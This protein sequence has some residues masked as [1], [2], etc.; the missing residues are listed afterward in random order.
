MNKE[1]IIAEELGIREEQVAAAL[2]LLEEGCTVPFI[3]RYRK[4]ETDSLDS[5]TL[6]RL[7][8]QRDRLDALESRR[9]TILFQIDAQGKLTEELKAEITA[10]N[11]LAVLEDLYRPYKKK[12]RTRGEKAR[13]AGYGDAGDALFNGASSA[14]LLEQFEDKEAARAGINDVAAERIGDDPAIRS[15]IRKEVQDHGVI[16]TE[17]KEEDPRFGMYA[18]FSERISSLPGHRI[19]AIN[20]GE[21]EGA[22]RV[23]VGIDDEQLITKSARQLSSSD[24]M[25][26]EA[27]NDAYYRLIFPS[28]ER[29]QRKVLTERAEEGALRVFERNLRPLLMAPPIKHKTVLALDPG[30]RNGCKTAI[31]GPDG[32]LLKY[33][34][35]QAAIKGHRQD[36]SRVA[37]QKLIEQYHPDLIA[38]GNGTASRETELFVKEVL[39]DIGREIPL[40]IVDE[41]GASIYSASPLADEEFPGV[42]VGARSAA[43]LGRRLQ[44]PLSELVKMDPKTL[45]V[46][47]Y[48]HDVNQKRLSEVL[49]GVVEACVNE[50]GVDVNT[51]SVPLLSFVAGLTK[52]N[53][54]SIVD[55]RSE[56]G[57]FKNR[58]QIK[59]VPGI[60]PMTYEQAAGFL[61]IVG[62]SCA[63]DNTAV[64][65]ESYEIA[66]S[67][68]KDLGVE[69]SALAEGKGVKVK[70]DPKD[71]QTVLDIKQELRRPGRDVRSDMPGPVF[72][73]SV[74]TI[75]DLKQGEILTGTVRNVTDFGAF[76]DVGV[77][78]DGLVHISQLSSKRFVKH[79]LD[80]LSV[81]DVIKVKVID[82]DVDKQRIQLSRKG[83]ED[84]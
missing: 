7:V 52:K 4:D 59:K 60:G 77:H 33:V 27:L 23:D 69:E 64:H 80:E 3:A 28:V 47:Q 65:P 29:E 1:L 18:E 40:A 10:A 62:G 39:S 66:R 25:L 45:G 8:E 42:D 31:I 76:V 22:L 68:L 78:C 67:I 61:R 26:K 75:E 11:T 53:A 21:K 51:A 71:S 82:V 34:V 74:M 44:D 70:D 15:I 81:G 56:Q 46:G 16:Q 12:R 55:Y 2:R 19:L 43:S 35:L 38:L 50:V 30:F 83:L 17:V 49:S 54:Q 36:E 20:R 5:E 58:A 6:R 63:L 57:P 48:Q 41:S 24:P 9:E 84:A 37:L 14:S 79:P 13:E 73:K 72:K 32:D